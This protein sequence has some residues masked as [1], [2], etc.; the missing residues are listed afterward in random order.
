MPR[1][2]AL[3]LL[4]LAAATALPT[5][6]NAAVKVPWRSFSG[7]LTNTNEPGLLRTADGRLHVAWHQPTP[8]RPAH[9]DL[10][11]RVIAKNGKLGPVTA[12]QSDW[13]GIGNPALVPT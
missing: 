8:A 12:I 13:Q 11:T 5:A 10:L 6:A 2:R 7:G 3:A 1:T 4:T 9:S